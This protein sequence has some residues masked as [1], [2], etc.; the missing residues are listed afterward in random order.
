MAL[1]TDV[2]GLWDRE[3]TY[4]EFGSVWDG[5]MHLSALI[6]ELEGNCLA[7]TSSAQ[8]AVSR[9]AAADFGLSTDI[10]EVAS[11]FK[12]LLVA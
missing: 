12:L 9:A 6:T 7:A 3:D 11:G 10:L 8:Q 1:S 5:V 2:N 4:D